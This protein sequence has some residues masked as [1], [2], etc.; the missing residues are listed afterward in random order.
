M[1]ISVHLSKPVNYT[2][3]RGNIGSLAVLFHNRLRGF[4][5][6]MTGW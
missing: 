1:G 2:A 5:D 3:M 4:P 6:I